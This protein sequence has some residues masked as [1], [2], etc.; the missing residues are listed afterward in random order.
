M[1]V[2]GMAYPQYW[3]C[4]KTTANNFL[5]HLDLIKFAFH[6]D[7]KLKGGVIVPKLLDSR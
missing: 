1:A 5:S 2:I 6:D 4:E 7:K 3:I